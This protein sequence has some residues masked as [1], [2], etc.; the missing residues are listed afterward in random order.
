MNFE[1][2]TEKLLH[3][4]DESPTAFQTVKNLGDMAEKAGFAELKETEEW[5]LEPGKSY[6]VKRNDSSIAAFSIPDKEPEKI[7]GFHMVAAHSDSPS[8]KVK[9]KAE[10]TAENLYVRLNVEK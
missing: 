3:F 7:K 1:K 9:E 2:E 5:S 10:M 8:F 6:Y 4:I